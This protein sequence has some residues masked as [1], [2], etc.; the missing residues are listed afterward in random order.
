MA[1]VVSKSRLLWACR[2]GMLELD[3]LF[4]P[5]VNDA[6]DDLAAPEKITFQRLL[7]CEDPELFCWFMGHQVCPDLELQQMIN[8]ILK[9]VKV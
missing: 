2:R 9:R 6:Y 4:V 7:S 8:V 5:F 1:E 3:L